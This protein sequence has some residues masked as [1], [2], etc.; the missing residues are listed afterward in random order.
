MSSWAHFNLNS[1][2]RSDFQHY[3]LAFCSIPLKLDSFPLSLFLGH[4]LTKGG[5]QGAPVST[6]NSPAEEESRL[7]PNIY[8]LQESEAFYGNLWRIPSTLSLPLSQ[9]GSLFPSPRDL[10]NNKWKKLNIY[11]ALLPF[12]SFFP[13]RS[14]DIKL[15]EIC[16]ALSRGA[17]GG[18]GAP[19]ERRGGIPWLG[20]LEI[21]D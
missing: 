4:P 17:K 1:Y 9:G 14:V 13:G 16:L 2:S 12:P 3:F 10:C 6:S 5:Q 15:W 18:R 8:N 21:G 11:V 7:P 19:A 20:R